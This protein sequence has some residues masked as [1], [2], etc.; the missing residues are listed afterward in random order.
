MLIYAVL[1]ALLTLLIGWLLPSPL[2]TKITSTAE[3]AIEVLGAFLSAIKIDADGKVR[4]TPEELEKITKE[5]R[6]LLDI[7]KKKS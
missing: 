4:I 6:D 3:E 2:Q 7:W 5:I 1:A